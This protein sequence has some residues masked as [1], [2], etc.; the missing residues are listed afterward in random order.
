MHTSLQPKTNMKLLALWGI[1]AVAV[2]F[3][4]SPTPWL[5]LVLGVAL[6]FCAGLIQLRAVPESA[7][8]LLTKQ[9][10]MD[11]RRVMNTSRSGQIY[12]YAFWASQAF[13]LPN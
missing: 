2:A 5:F 11:V 4:A 3:I 13:A 10:L 1:V 9:T 6:G 8:S 7:A 12:L